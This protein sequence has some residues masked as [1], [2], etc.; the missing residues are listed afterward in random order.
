MDN[1]INKLEKAIKEKIKPE[2]IDD[3]VGIS[4]TV[5]TIKKSHREVIKNADIVLENEQDNNV[6]NLDQAVNIVYWTYFEQ[7]STKFVGITWLD[8]NKMMIIRGS[9][10]TP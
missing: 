7:N 6:I 5:N 9:I 4:S 10:L 1:L 3:F 8:D 2:E